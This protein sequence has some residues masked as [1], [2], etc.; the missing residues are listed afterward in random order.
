M[1]GGSYDYAYCRLEDLSRQI[2]EEGCCSCASPYLRRAFAKHLLDISKAMRAIEW[3]DS[4]DG[5]DE[6]TEL[7][8]KCLPKNTELKECLEHA[9]VVLKD[10]EKLINKQEDKQ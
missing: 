3:N 7:I 5:D 1:S 10:L 8:K 6:E 4:S 2:R 9:K